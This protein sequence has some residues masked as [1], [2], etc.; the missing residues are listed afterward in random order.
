MKKLML[1][2]LLLAI[3]LFPAAAGRSV[4]AYSAEYGQLTVRILADD[5]YLYRNAVV[6]DEN[7]MFL[8]TK[9]YYLIAYEIGDALFYEV[10][11]QTTEEGYIPTIGYV[12]KSQV[13][14]CEETPELISPRITATAVTNEMIRSLPSDSAPVL[15]CTTTGQSVL[16]YGFL[17]L[18]DGT[19]YAFVRY[20][21]KVG[22][23][24]AE[25]L[26]IP[27]IPMHPNPL[28]QPE[29]DPIPDPDEGGDPNGGGTTGEPE[30]D[31]D[32]PVFDTKMQIILIVAIVIPA[33]FIAYLM[34]RPSRRSRDR[35]TPSGYSRYS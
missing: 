29:P 10:E 4:R 34:F 32:A 26:N 11:Y 5:V 12:L 20:G 24:R 28:P 3:V 33:L 8:L 30:P 16:I 17:P 31:P 18:E 1:L 25:S 35:Q 21:S 2:P 7:K 19:R 15:A 22:Y 23:V 27:E 14:L 13:T 6:S 9:S